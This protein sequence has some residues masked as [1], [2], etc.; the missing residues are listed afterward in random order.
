MA[1]C[2]SQLWRGLLCLWS[3]FQIVWFGNIHST[4][5]SCWH[6]WIWFWL[7][8]ACALLWVCLCCQPGLEYVW[9]ERIPFSHWI[10]PWNPESISFWNVDYWLIFQY[11]IYELYLD[12]PEMLKD[13]RFYPLQ[14]PMSYFCWRWWKTETP[15]SE[16]KAF[17]VWSIRFCSQFSIV[18]KGHGTM[19]I[20]LGSC[21]TRRVC[22]SSEE[23]SLGE[24]FNLMSC[25]VL[26]NLSKLC[27]YGFCS[28]TNLPAR[29]YGNIILIGPGCLQ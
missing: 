18:F 3:L 14:K 13:L 9:G 24:R 4:L 1:K 8:K 6:A 12:M 21:F 28:Q 15:G 11:D 23:L 27:S 17:S 2:P 29:S 7:S 10:T 22:A 25:D 26:P 5:L 19:E 20:G 16:S